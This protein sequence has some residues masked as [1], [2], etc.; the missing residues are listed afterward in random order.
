MNNSIFKILLRQNFSS[1]LPLGT[2]VG[3]SILGGLVGISIITHDRIYLSGSFYYCYRYKLSKRSN[4][5]TKSI[6]HGISSS[7]RN[8]RTYWIILILSTGKK[9]SVL[10]TKTISTIQTMNNG[11][12][13]NYLKKNYVRMRFIIIDYTVIR[14]D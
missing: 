9:C 12:T 8:L 14:D 10:F 11:L 1:L 4:L 6:E 13:R 5:R 7:L 2:I 3:P